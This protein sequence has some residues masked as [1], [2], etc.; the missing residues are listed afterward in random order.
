V[1][2]ILAALQ[3]QRA[4]QPAPAAQVRALLQALAQAPAGREDEGT[5][6]LI[7]DSLSS[8]DLGDAPA[9]VRVRVACGACRSGLLLLLRRVGAHLHLQ[10][11]GLRRPAAQRCDD[12]C[13]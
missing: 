8:L 13:G 4:Q 7:R 3:R 9:Q 11:L 10:G 12:P 6:R 1:S 2:R 5:G